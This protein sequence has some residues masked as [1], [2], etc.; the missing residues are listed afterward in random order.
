MG[1]GLALGAGAE[2]LDLRDTSRL[3]IGIGDR[4]AV[5]REGRWVSTLAELDRRKIRVDMIEIWLTSDWRPDWIPRERLD[6]L[7][8]RNV[9][10]VIVHYFFGDDISQERFED[11]RDAWYSSL[12]EMAQR[13]RGDASVL[14]ILEPE[15]NVAPPKG[16][17]AITSWP[18]FA[19][20]LR[21]AAK[22]IRKQAPNALVGTCPG[23]FQ[24]AP[25]LEPVL[26]PVADD[27]DFLAFQEM[28][29][30]T[31]PDR[32]RE[33][34]LPVGRAALDYARYLKRAFGRPILLGYVAV[35]SYGGWEEQQARAL[36]E[37]M[38]NSREL[39][40]AGVWGLVYFELFDDVR[41][42]GYFGDAE[43][44]FGLLTKDGRQKPALEVFRALGTLPAAPTPGG[45]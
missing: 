5:Q 14:V 12:W 39:R 17:T 9:T 6:E 15:F 44:H 35:S 41:H 21:A 34:D 32:H 23:D 36:R 45:R 13:I 3:R 4:L 37:L 18:E 38:T 10:P 33:G 24:G 28:R 29:A 20:D 30:S 31:D 25:L 27:L 8:A 16:E 2:P 7:A 22:L 19:D 26:G 40:D 11:R 1:L 42:S 43:R